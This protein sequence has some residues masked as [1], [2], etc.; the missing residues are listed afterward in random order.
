MNFFSFFDYLNREVFT[1][2][3]SYLP[4]TDGVRMM[5]LQN[6]YTV[7]DNAAVANAV[8]KK[9]LERTI[10]G[11]SNK[12]TGLTDIYAVKFDVNDGFHG[13]SLNGGSVIDKYLPNFA[14]PGTVKDAE[15]EMIAATVLKNTQHAG[16]LRNIKIA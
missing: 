12:T 1:Q 5:D 13:I 2:D 11:A 16:V 4:D 14:T 15:V 10:N 8:V 9:G 3:A 7:S 6:Y